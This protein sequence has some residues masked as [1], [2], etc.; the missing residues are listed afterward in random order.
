LF[1]AYRARSPPFCS[2]FIVALSISSV[3]VSDNI[4]CGKLDAQ[5]VAD[6]A[7]EFRK[8]AVELSAAGLGDGH[9]NKAKFKTA[10]LP[11][12]KSAFK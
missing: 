3:I 10:E 2:Q 1:Y 6:A 11:S 8:S 4:S 9:E 12:A 5:A 7:A